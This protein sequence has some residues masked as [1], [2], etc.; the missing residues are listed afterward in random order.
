MYVNISYHRNHLLHGES[1]IQRCIAH[2][3][4]I[5]HPCGNRGGNRGP[6]NQPSHAD[7]VRKTRGRHA[8]DT[9]KT[10]PS[11]A[12]TAADSSSNSTSRSSSAI[13]SCIREAA[14]SGV[15]PIMVASSIPVVTEGQSISPVTQMRCN[16]VC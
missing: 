10:Q 12:A 7:E 13:T 11:P 14:Y 16:G 1:S 4:H 9:R 15:L 3:G 8:E 5:F 6:I 2:N